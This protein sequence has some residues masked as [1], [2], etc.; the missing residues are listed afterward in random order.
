MLLE[1]DIA[2]SGRV[3]KYKSRPGT[4]GRREKEPDPGEA[5]S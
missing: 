2:D 4:S 1:A 5:H 3:F